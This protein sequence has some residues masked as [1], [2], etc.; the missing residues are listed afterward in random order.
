M[1][2]INCTSSTS[3]QY[4][5]IQR[6][7]TSEYWVSS[8]LEVLHHVFRSGI[9]FSFRFVGVRPIPFVFVSWAED[10]PV[11]T[12]KPILR[13]SWLVRNSKDRLWNVLCPIDIVERW[14]EDQI[15]LDLLRDLQ[16]CPGPTFHSNSIS[17]PSIQEYYLQALDC[18]SL[19]VDRSILYSLQYVH[20]S[21]P[22]I[23][24]HP[25][26]RVLL[27]SPTWSLGRNNEDLIQG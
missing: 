20:T 7:D 27:F 9:P 4:S 18:S 2:W 8:F 21:F 23:T 25:S 22:Y 19:G 26:T 3:F 17:W 13:S 5:S 12:L 14:H 6:T 24:L 1:K 16:R 11:S 15:I 10:D